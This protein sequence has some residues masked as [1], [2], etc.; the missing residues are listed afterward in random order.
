MYYNI[1]FCSL[2]FKKLLTTP[3]HTSLSF[4][5]NGSLLVA[6]TSNGTIEVWQS[7]NTPY[8][9]EIAQTQAGIQSLAYSPCGIYVFSSL[10]ESTKIFVWEAEEMSEQPQATLDHHNGRPTVIHPLSNSIHI[11]VAYEEGFI[12]LWNINSQSIEREFKGHESEITCIDTTTNQDLVISGDKKGNVFVWNFFHGRRLRRFMEHSSRVVAVSFYQQKYMISADVNG[13][14]IIK[15]FITASV[16][17]NKTPH[18]GHISVLTSARIR[19]YDAIASGH[20]NGIIKIWKLS[21]MEEICS[22]R[23]H[24]GAVS[25]I[26]LI[27]SKSFDV[28]GCITTSLDK[29]IRM[30]NLKTSECLSILF[31]DYPITCSSISPSWEIAT[32]VYGSSSIGMLWYDFIIEDGDQ[33]RT[34]NRVLEMLRSSQK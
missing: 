30:W 11:L 21:S 19:Y 24:T 28:M 6:G 32:L 23:G 18:G 31:T 20:E 22:L 17:Y 3:S 25:S 16:L 13:C 5:N 26:H 14:I 7:Q 15:D 27:P 1:V 29:S 9:N 33:Q 34:S 2:L 12:L 10:N 8:S 4:A